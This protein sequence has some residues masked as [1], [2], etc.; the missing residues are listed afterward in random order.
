[1]QG[2]SKWHQDPNGRAEVA[3]AKFWERTVPD[4]IVP[5]GI[6]WIRMSLFTKFS[7][8]FRDKANECEVVDPV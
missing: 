4:E 2:Q 6:G 7:T 8:H 1:M 5:P 3:V